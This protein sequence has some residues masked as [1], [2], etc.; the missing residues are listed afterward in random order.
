MATD[1]LPC[2]KKGCSGKLILIDGGKVLT[3]LRCDTCN[4]AYTLKKSLNEYYKLLEKWE[5]W[6][7]LP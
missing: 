4:R 6:W 2:S 1:N 7:G 5:D 3:R